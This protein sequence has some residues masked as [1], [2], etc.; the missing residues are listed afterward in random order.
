[1]VRLFNRIVSRRY[2]SK[3]HVCKQITQTQIFN[4]HKNWYHFLLIYQS[5]WLKRCIK[6]IGLSKLAN[7][8]L[9]KNKLLR[10]KGFFSAEMSTSPPVN[11]SMDYILVSAK[12]MNDNKFI[13]LTIASILY[14]EIVFVYIVL[15]FLITESNL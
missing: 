5:K 1:M 6:P 4:T 15:F 9:L 3:A 8:N 11:S 13:P 7:K 10:S 2:L 14:F 12:L